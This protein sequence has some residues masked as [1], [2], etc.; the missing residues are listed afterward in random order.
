MSNTLTGVIAKIFET[1]QVSEK[2]TKRELVINT[3]EQYPQSV[4]LQFT[5]DKCSVLDNYKE[6]QTVTLSYNLQ[7]R[8]WVDP[9]T[10]E[11][12][13]FNTLQA[14][15]IEKADGGPHPMQQAAAQPDANLVP[16]S[17]D[18]NDLPF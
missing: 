10:S 14:W 5:K 11:V 6:G 15:K 13:Y 4:I 2:F 1:K 7:G 12:R 9:K 8:E 17:N 3:A 16:T 18:S